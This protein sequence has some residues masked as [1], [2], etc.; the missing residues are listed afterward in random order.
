MIIAVLR[1]YAEGWARDEAGDLRPHEKAS[2]RG[3]ARSRAE[4]LILVLAR[5]HIPEQA[6]GWVVDAIRHL[7][8][9]MLPPMVADLYA[10]IEGDKGGV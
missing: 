10:E 9:E 2:A 8:P 3:C 5:M 4:A 6:R 1:R 7:P